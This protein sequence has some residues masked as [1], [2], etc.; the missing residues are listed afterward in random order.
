M[1]FPPSFYW[2]E[3]LILSILGKGEGG[4]KLEQ[5]IN[6]FVSKK[7]KDSIEMATTKGVDLAA[8]S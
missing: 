8:E 4:M 6:Y 1:R 2:I 3:P 7:K 5:E